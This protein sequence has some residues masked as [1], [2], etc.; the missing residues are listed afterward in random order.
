M[1][2]L[3]MPVDETTSTSGAFPGMASDDDEYFGTYMR[4]SDFG[5]PEADADQVGVVLWLHKG[6]STVGQ[7]WV[8]QQA[9]CRS[10]CL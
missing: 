7:A 3:T 1:D 2:D 8:V 6:S 5:S 10:A 9:V 4:A